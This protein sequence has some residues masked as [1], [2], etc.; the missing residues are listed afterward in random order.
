MNNLAK[1]AGSVTGRPVLMEHGAIEAWSAKL[2]QVDARV[3]ERPGRLGALMR[4]IAGSHMSAPTSDA[5]GYPV[6]FHQALAY[7]PMYIGE[8][9][10]SGFCWTL[11]NGVALMCV[12]TPLLDEG[13][14]YCGT[15]FHG[16]DTLL[17]A[18]QEA[19]AD[20]RVGGIF[21][22]MN[23]PGG[24]ATGGVITLAKWMRENRGKAGGKPIHVYAK[25]ACSG[26]Q[27]IAAQA[28]KTVCPELAYVGSIGAY[29]VHEDWSG[30][31]E[32]AGI[33]IEEFSMFE[34]KTDGADF[35]PMSDSGKVDALSDI[36]Q[37]V[38]LFVDD[39]IAGRPNLTK[40]G[41][42]A[43]RSRAFFSR[44]DDPERS[45]VALGLVDEITDEVSA[46]NALAELVSA[47]AGNDNQQ[48]SRAGRA[49][50]FTTK[51]QTMADNTGKAAR[52]A[53]LEAQKAKIDAQIAQ[54]SAE[55]DGED[56]QEG[57]EGNKKPDGAE[58]DAAE[59]AASDEAKDDP[60]LALSAIQQGLSCAQFKALAAVS[61]AG[62]NGRGQL[63]RVMT[64]SPRVGPDSLAGKGSAVSLNPA[65]IYAARRKAAGTR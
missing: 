59:I 39:M 63:G 54:A 52:V 4:K 7:S 56:L 65:G 64:G 42:K 25:M 22:K 57:Q 16:Y 41:I 5:D 46:F 32:K 17:A 11:K 34:N 28:D 51:E 49:A 30:A 35:K 13:E 1:L 3:M 55:P 40:D 48:A 14:I 29:C 60:A 37:I 44:H 58:D 8:P 62:T 43:M 26:A 36:G 9:D 15:C 24:F 61:K 50:V 45:G 19:S 20:A 53:A 47:P 27:W 38:N 31:Y 33:R 2:R 12:D 23:C 6:V 21:L 10:D 18:M